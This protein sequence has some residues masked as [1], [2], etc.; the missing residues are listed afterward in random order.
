MLIS[1]INQLLNEYL[2]VHG[3]ELHPP[4]LCLEVGVSTSIT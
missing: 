4:T 3:D 1:E 2:K